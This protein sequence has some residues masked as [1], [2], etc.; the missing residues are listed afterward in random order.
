V[1]RQQPGSPEAQRILAERARR[2]GRFVEAE[3]LMSV[4]EPLPQ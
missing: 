2:E 1:I 4:F 3:D